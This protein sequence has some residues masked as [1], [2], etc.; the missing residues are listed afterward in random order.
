M[1]V[2]LWCASV[3][4]DIFVY[5]TIAGGDQSGKIINNLIQKDQLGPALRG[6][7]KKE[8]VIVTKFNNN[9]NRCAVQTEGMTTYYL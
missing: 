3:D 1:A 6:Q 7:N 2:Q 5:H 8:I 4:L 9:G